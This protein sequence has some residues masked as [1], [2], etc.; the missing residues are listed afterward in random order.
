VAPGLFATNLH[1]RLEHR[2]QTLGAACDTDLH[3]CLLTCVTPAVSRCHPNAGHGVLPGGPRF[4]ET[5]E[6]RLGFVHGLKF[7]SSSCPYQYTNCPSHSYR[8]DTPLVATIEKTSKG[9][10]N[11]HTISTFVAFLRNNGLAVNTIMGSVSP[12][13]T[14]CVLAAV[15]AYSVYR[16]L[17]LFTA[18]RPLA[19][20]R[21][22]P[23]P[24]WII[25]HY[26]DFREY[27]DTE[28]IYDTIEGWFEEYGSVLR[29]RDLGNVRLCTPCDMSQSNLPN[30]YRNHNCSLPTSRHSHIS[31]CTLRRITNRNGFEWNLL[32]S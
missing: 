20:L 28:I 21:G 18:P 6:H 2:H 14:I 29:W 26:K 1:L 24:S 8:Q 22:P 32:G 9:L 7:I 15:V 23:S 3:S 25:G 12:T 5:A 4:G 10:A 31:S 30:A 11:L 19:S 13:Y 16:I 17:K 27:G